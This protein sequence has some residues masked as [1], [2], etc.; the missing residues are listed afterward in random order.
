MPLMEDGQAVEADVAALTTLGLG[1]K[2]TL[3]IGEKDVV[4]YGMLASEDGP[5]MP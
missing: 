4:F 3:T 2:K 5:T 1:D